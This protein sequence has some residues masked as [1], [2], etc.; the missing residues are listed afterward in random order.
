MSNYVDSDLHLSFALLV[1]PNFV[2]SEVLG[3][4][5]ESEPDGPAFW[6]TLLL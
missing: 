4:S 6:C 5:R 1:I 3:V 2:D